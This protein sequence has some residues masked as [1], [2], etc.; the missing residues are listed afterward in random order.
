MFALTPRLTLRPGWPEDA[1]ELA[2]A[3][4]HE[5]VA[6]R[7]ARVPWPY[8]EADAHRFLSQPRGATDPVF[9]ITERGRG[10]RLVGGIGIHP[11]E[12][13]HELGYWLTPSAWGNGYATEAARAVVMMARDALRLPIL[14]AT[15]FEGNDASAR[16][17]A[18][19]GF[20]PTGRTARMPCLALGRDVDAV[21]SELRLD[22]ARDDPIPM[23]A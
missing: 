2:R 21:E 20:R 18:K 22:D 6:T 13:S 5:A 23:A 16:V 14:R 17:L 11:G 3:I 10:G 9:L 7:L 8:G 12:P 1:P 4:G 19:L 15:A